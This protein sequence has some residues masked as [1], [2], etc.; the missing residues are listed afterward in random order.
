M[1]EDAVYE[2]RIEDL[3]AGMGFER[4]RVLEF[5]DGEPVNLSDSGPGDTAQATLFYGDWK[6]ARGDVYDTLVKHAEDGYRRARAYKSPEGWYM[7]I[8]ADRLDT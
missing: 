2:E 6:A 7:V 8:C 5:K 3:L 4:A 1:I